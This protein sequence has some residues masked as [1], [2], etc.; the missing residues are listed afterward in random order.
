M[1]NNRSSLVWVEP[2]DRVALYME[3][4]DEECVQEIHERVGDYLGA[5]SLVGKRFIYPLSLSHA[6]R[7]VSDRLAL[8]GDAAH[9]M[10]PI[11]G[12]GVNV[13]F[14]DVAVLAELVAKQHDMGLD[15]GDNNL[16]RRYQRWRS[17]DNVAM[18][19]ATDGLNRLFSNNS[20]PIKF[21]RDLGLWAVG[22]MPPL[23]QFFMNNAMGLTGDLP[24]LMRRQN[25]N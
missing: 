23:K 10:H 1:Q 13:G 6:R 18:L 20:F 19:A 8:I 11:A 9:G 22:R 7:Y 15:I 25:I 12:Q 2:D 3:L 4:S 17:F 21:A 16:L 5:I 14:R 24:E